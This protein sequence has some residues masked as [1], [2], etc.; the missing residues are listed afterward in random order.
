MAAVRLQVPLLAVHK[1]PV[2]ATVTT[3]DLITATAVA[4]VAAMAACV[5][6]SSALRLPSPIAAVAVPAAMA[7]AAAGARRA[8]LAMMHSPDLVVVALGLVALAAVAMVAAVRAGGPL[9]GTLLVGIVIADLLIV[10]VPP[11]FQFCISAGCALPSRA[12]RCAGGLCRQR[13][14]HHEGRQLRKSRHRR[15]CM[16]RSRLGLRGIRWWQRRSTG[17]SS[18]VS[19]EGERQRRPDKA[20]TASG[21]G[22]GGHHTTV[23]ESVARVGATA[24]VQ[25]RRL[26]LSRLRLQQ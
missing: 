9:L 4:T 2:L 3:V 18:R 21:L 13:R 8:F 16:A 22:E 6:L 24:A 19:D 20:P 15:L 25:H 10:P 7:M 5:P 17:S 14:I 26:L 11:P 1:P 23:A 12:L